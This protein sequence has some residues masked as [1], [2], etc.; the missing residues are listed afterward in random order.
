[1]DSAPQWDI[2]ATGHTLAVSRAGGH[3]VSHYQSL[4]SPVIPTYCR[5]LFGKLPLPPHQNV[6][7]APVTVLRT[8]HHR[9]ASGL[10]TH[11]VD[12]PTMEPLP[13]VGANSHEVTLSPLRLTM[14]SGPQYPGF[15][16][17]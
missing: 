6:P 16:P 2:L 8:T 12:T 9:R 11:W 10:D 17:F 4:A 7:T 13:W 15:T 5:R 14:D 1:V 3:P